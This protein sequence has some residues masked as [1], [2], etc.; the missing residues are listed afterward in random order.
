MAGAH[1]VLPRSLRL[2]RG[3]CA[4]AA[5]LSKTPGIIRPLI[6][7]WQ[8]LSTASPSGAHSGDHRVTKFRQLLEKKSAQW[9]VMTAAWFRLL[10]QKVVPLPRTERE[11][12]VPGP[13]DVARFERAKVRRSVQGTKRLRSYCR[14]L[15]RNPAIE[16][17]HAAQ[18]RVARTYVVDDLFLLEHA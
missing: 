1:A 12:R 16:E 10:T 9:E 15:L 2:R 13:S 8:S 17:V 5:V 4:L 11:S 7:S 14:C 18:R 3:T 6:A